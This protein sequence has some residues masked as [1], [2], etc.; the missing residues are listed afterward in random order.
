MFALISLHIFLYGCNLFM[1][2][3]TRINHN[4]I[5]DFK[6]N[7]ALKHRDAFLISSAFMTAVV[8]AMVAH[9]FLKYN[10]VSSHHLEALPGILILVS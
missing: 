1:W 2:K 4:F 8:S 7:T 9:L 6:P 5:F 3:N 10:H